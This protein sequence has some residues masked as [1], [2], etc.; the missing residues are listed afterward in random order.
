MRSPQSSRPNPDAGFASGLV[1]RNIVQV[2]ERAARLFPNKPAIFDAS[3][4]PH[5]KAGHSYT[6]SDVRRRVIAEAD[7]LVREGLASGDRVGVLSFNS[8]HYFEL[9]FAVPYKG[10][11]LVPLNFRL[12]DDELAAQLEETEPTI[13]VCDKHFEDRAISLAKRV[14]SVKSLLCTE[15]ES[16][17]SSL[18][19]CEETPLAP[20]EEDDTVGIFYTGGAGGSSKGAMLTHRNLFDATLQISLAMGY[21][22]DDVYLHAGPMF[23]L[24][25]GAGSLASTFV[26]AAHVF[27]P[28]FSAEQVVDAI[29]RYGVTTMTLVPTMYRMLLDSPAFDPSRMKSLRRIF[30]SAAP[31]SESLMRRIFELLPCGVGQGYGMTEASSR[32]SVMLPDTYKAVIEGRDE[33]RHL[34]SSA[35]REVPGLCVRIVDDEGDQLPPYEVGEI[36]VSGTV[37]MKGYWRRPDLTRKALRDGWLHTGDLGYLDGDGFLYIV[38]RLKDMII[39]GG[40]NVYS[41][42]VENVLCSHP[43]VVEAAVV[44]LPDELWGERVSAFVVLREGAEVE[45]DSLREFCRRRIAGYKTPKDI[46]FVGELPRSAA[47]KVLKE[48]LKRRYP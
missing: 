30:F 10:G 16:W 44:G 43:D 22:E 6:W 27:V 32:I 13:L 1:Q 15:D 42:E 24:A 38:D 40:E 45:K 46:F 14:S 47:G 7:L 19:S 4:H 20:S 35:G 31:M 29:E 25:D 36:A 3:E 2:L 17:E 39:T 37:V 12:S 5:C 41:L 11:L 34:L 9:Y 33:R 23:H 18:L 8:H 21:L 48:E 26:G 28:S